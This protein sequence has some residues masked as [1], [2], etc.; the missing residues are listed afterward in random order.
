MRVIS[1][2]CE[3]DEEE[4]ALLRLLQSIYTQ[5]PIIATVPVVVL[6]LYDDNT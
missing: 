2:H 3:E 6:F 4:T 5:D 1:S